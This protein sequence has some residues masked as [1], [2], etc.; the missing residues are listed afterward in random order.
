MIHTTERVCLCKVK[1]TIEELE[2]VTLV[3]TNAAGMSFFTI[4]HMTIFILLKKTFL[5]F[6]KSKVVFH[7]YF[8]DVSLITGLVS[9]S[10][11]PPTAFTVSRFS[12]VHFSGSK[13]QNV[14]QYSSAYTHL[15]VLLSS[16]KANK[17][18][19]Y[20]KK[21]VMRLISLSEKKK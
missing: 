3:H 9:V 11:A 21:K 2:I 4:L 12:C 18:T 16:R 1:Q 5:L 15:C 14:L 7:L 17:Y 10:E 6:N 8:S 13:L 20:L 19:S